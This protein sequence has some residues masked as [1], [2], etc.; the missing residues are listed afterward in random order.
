MTAS[1]STTRRTRVSSIA[2]LGDRQYG[3][4]HV[5]QLVRLGRTRWAINRRVNNGTWRRHHRCVIQLGIGRPE[6]RATWMAAVLACGP[7]AV[8]TGMAAAE[9]WGLSPIP[10]SRIDVVAPSM[11]NGALDGVEVHRTRWFGRN[12]RTVRYGIPIASVSRTIVDC[13]EFVDPYELVGLL[14]RA[15]RRRLL[16]R[17]QL[18][19]VRRRLRN[20]RHGHA[21]LQF[22]LDQLRAGSTGIHSRAELALV[23]AIRAAG[24]PLPLVNVVVQT[25]RGTFTF[26]LW[27]PEHGCCIEVD[28]RGHELLV[29]RMHDRGR[30][31]AAA[32]AGIDLLRVPNEFV[33]HQLDDVL[34]QLRP[35]LG[36]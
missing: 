1:D 16:R 27:W 15:L 33:F 36:A 11:P 18:D 5:H 28:D 31:E 20:R 4:A 22:A 8:L 23:Q 7:G 29:V 3:V 6:R 19:I 13:A 9:H 2:E 17:R 34:H 32:D 14:Y 30:E 10:A 26:D 24:L 21:A 12:D 25:D 35:M